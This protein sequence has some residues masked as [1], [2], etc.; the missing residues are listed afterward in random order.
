MMEWYL[1]GRGYDD[2]HIIMT[3][4]NKSQRLL[5]NNHAMSLIDYTQSHTPHRVK[6]FQQW[7]NEWKLIFSDPLEPRTIDYGDTLHEWF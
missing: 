3:S 7:S 5:R 1:R 2:D 4:K 6:M